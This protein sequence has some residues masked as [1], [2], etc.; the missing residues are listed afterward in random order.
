MIDAKTFFTDFQNEFVD[1][2]NLNIG[3][4]TEFKKIESW[5]SLT[6]M[7]ISVMIQDKYSVQ[8]S[9]DDF[10]SFTT[11]GDVLNRVMENHK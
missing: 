11:A 4:A 1:P 7:A 8:I 6:G 10:Q 3:A 9:D 2:E 5:D